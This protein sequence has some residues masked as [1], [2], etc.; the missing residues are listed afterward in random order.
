MIFLSWRVLGD[1][2]LWSMTIRFESMEKYEFDLHTRS[3]SI[4]LH[5]TS[6]LPHIYP[7]LD[8]NSFLTQGICADI[9]W[10]SGEGTAHRTNNIVCI[11]AT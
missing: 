2:K 9:L 10:T 3:Q 1:P 8:A 11:L 7:L 5:Y 6:P 4:I